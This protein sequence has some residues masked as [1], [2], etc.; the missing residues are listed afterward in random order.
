MTIC[1]WISRA[2]VEAALLD[3]LQAN[4]YIGDDGIRAARAT[5]RS[6]LD[7]GEQVPHPDLPIRRSPAVAAAMAAVVTPAAPMPAMPRT[8]RRLVPQSRRGF[9]RRSWR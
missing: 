3:A 6:G 7:A 8:T 2:D 1:G 9:P 4:G 5:L